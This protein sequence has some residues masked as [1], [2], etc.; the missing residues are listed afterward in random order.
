MPK[1]GYKSPYVS[2][3]H[4]NYAREWFLRAL[5]QGA[6]GAAL[7]QKQLSCKYPVAKSVKSAVGWTL[8]CMN[9][10]RSRSRSRSRITFNRIHRASC[11]WLPRLMMDAEQVT[12]LRI[13]SGSNIQNCVARVLQTLEALPAQAVVRL[14]AQGNAVAKA[15]TIAEISR[16]RLRRLHQ[17]TQ[18]GLVRNA[19]TESSSA[20]N[21]SIDASKSEP[22][23]TISITLSFCL[24]DA[25]QPG[26][27]PPLTE[28]ELLSGW[29]FDD[30]A[31]KNAVARATDRKKR[32]RPHK[33]PRGDA[34]LDPLPPAPPTLPAP[35]TL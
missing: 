11:A 27:Q 14:I 26:Y 8:V 23:P 9:S 12:Q 16:R 10:S 25:S 35:R 4:S 32:S 31:P 3:C 22:V 20:A 21:T 7:S 17:N 19:G 29:I 15:V 30:D 18:V 1:R 24:L 6:H 33:R 13:A 5:R 34:A 2:L 28:D